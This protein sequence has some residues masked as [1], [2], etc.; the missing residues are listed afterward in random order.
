MP[1]A[2]AKTRTKTKVKTKAKKAPVQKLNFSEQAQENVRNVFLVGLGAYGKA[3]DEAQC[4]LK[5]AQ[6][7]LQENRS[8]AEDLLGQLLKRGEEVESNAKSRMQQIDLPELKLP[9]LKLQAHDQFRARLD[10]ARGS[11]D[12]LRNAIASKQ[13]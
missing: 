12:T 11:F 8:K 2:T 4:Q 5:D 1:P 6:T 10:K 13:T 3:I 7:Q 9:Q